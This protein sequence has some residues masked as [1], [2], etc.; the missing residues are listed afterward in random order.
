MRSNYFKNRAQ[1]S[2]KFAKVYKEA[3]IKLYN[4]YFMHTLSTP[5]KDVSKIGQAI[6]SRLKRLGIETVED[7]IFYFP[8]RYD[9]FSEVL[10]ISELKPGIKATIQGKVDLIHNK[11][12]PV[13][14]KIITEAMITDETGAIKAVWFNQ[15]FL[16]K[17]L[18]IGDKVFFA[19]KVDYDYFGIQMTSPSYEKLSYSKDTAHTGRLVPI[20]SITENLTQKQIRT[21]IKIVIEAVDGIKEY[22]PDEILEKYSFLDIKRAIREIHFPSSNKFLDEAKKRLKFDELFL[23]QFKSQILRYNLRKKK[24]IRLEFK[25][26]EVVDFVKKFPFKLT[27][28]QRKAAWEILKDLQREQP[29]NRLLEGDVGSGKTAVAAIAMYNAVLNSYQAVMMAPTEILASQHFNSLS[30][31]FGKFGVKVGLLTRTERKLEIRNL[32]FENSSLNE[33][34]REKITKSKIIK[35][36]KDGEVDIIIGT[37]A[38]LQENVEFKN[39]ALA[40][41]DEQHR[42]GVQQRKM[43]REKS[44][45][46]NIMPHFLSMTATPI[47]RSLALT[48]YGDLDLSILDQ[49]PIGRKKIITKVVA[50]ENRGKAYEFIRKQI[51]QGRQTF[52]ICP[53]IDPSDKMGFKSVTEEYKKLNEEIFKDIKMGMLHGKMKSKEKE[54]IMARFLAQEIKILVSTSVVEVGVDVP[55]ASV[56]MIEG[57]DHFGLA[58]LH[59]FRGRVGRSEHQSYCF[60]FSNA[61]GQNSYERLAVLEQ[62]NNGFELAEKDLAF[63]GPGQVYGIEQSGIPN[64]KIANF[65][66]YDIIKKAKDE[67]EKIMKIDPSLEKWAV[68]REKV[69]KVADKTHLE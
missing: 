26:Y 36:I 63:R 3:D 34:G 66:D 27:D 58:Q 54:E 21:L 64:L 32:K 45:D 49:M 6:A 17:T 7:L 50:S 23:L 18:L 31:L 33:C 13:K 28:A 1:I 19:G 20:Y 22:L 4:F 48:V 30:K 37:H 51:E 41:V 39:L 47:P 65:S 24:S 29:M 59:Q 55:N 10:K 68:L 9:D 11:R 46:Q 16:T 2:G 15:P 57:A 35:I 8:F 67:V 43:L 25:E 69:G 12:S 60:L 52:V 53:L 62:N 40:I 56:I 38:L 44:G 5:I 14:R 42:F 61:V